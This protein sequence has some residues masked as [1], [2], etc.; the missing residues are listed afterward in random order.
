MLLPLIPVAAIFYGLMLGMYPAVTLIVT[1]SL[2]FL[3][4]LNGFIIEVFHR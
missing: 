3:F 4:F 1:G 2:I